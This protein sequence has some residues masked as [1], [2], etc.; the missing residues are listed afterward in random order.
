MCIIYIFIFALLEEG[1][2]VIPFSTMK[3]ERQPQFLRPL[4]HP[5]Y[6]FGKDLDGTRAAS[7]LMMVL[8]LL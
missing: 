7:L 6:F 4:P 5:V 3:L 8:C 2:G 1:N